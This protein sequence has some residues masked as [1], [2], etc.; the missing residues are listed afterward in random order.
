MN[1][2]EDGL[3][4]RVRWRHVVG[5]TTGSAELRR[6]LEGLNKECQF[7]GST[8]QALHT[9]LP[10]T[11]H[12][13]KQVARETRSEHLRDDENVRGQSRLQHD[14]HV[15]GVEQLDGVGTTLATESVALDRDFNAESLEVD[16]DS[17]NDDSRDQ[18][19]DVG[20]PLPPE[21]LPEGTSLVVPGE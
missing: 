18:A 13:N 1:W 11:K 17:E 2:V 19:H 20:E 5:D 14:G 16:D 4:D 6:V 3:L 8:S 10:N 12:L 21:R 7:S 15:R 9:D